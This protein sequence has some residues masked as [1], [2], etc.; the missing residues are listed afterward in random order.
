VSS[1]GG[2]SGVLVVRR[3]DSESLEVELG[4]GCI[5]VIEAQLVV[6]VGVGDGFC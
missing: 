5:S 4:G 6:G 1:Q 2:R 3:C